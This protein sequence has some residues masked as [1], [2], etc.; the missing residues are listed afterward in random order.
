MVTIKNWLNNAIF[1]W[2]KFLLI[3][4]RSIAVLDMLDINLVGFVLLPI[5]TN[6]TLDEKVST[7]C[8]QGHN[9]IDLIRCLMI[10]LNDGMKIINV[11]SSDFSLYYKNWDKFICCCSTFR[12]LDF[13]DNFQFCSIF[14]CY[15][16]N[17][18][19]CHIY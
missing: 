2:L 17:C 9:D 13:N 4:F 1:R 8:F 6:A 11:H 3:S 12:Y 16:T 18:K 19:T 15:R 7:G 14:K 5:V 10:I